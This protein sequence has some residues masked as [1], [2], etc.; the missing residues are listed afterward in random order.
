MIQLTSRGVVFSGSAA[1]LRALRAQ[2]K[3]DHYIILPKLIEPELLATILK[4]IESAPSIPK[5]FD[6]FVAQSIIDDPH[7]NALFLFLLCI[8]EFQRLI[9]RIAGCRRISDFHGRIYTL[10]PGTRDRIV[11][12]NDCVR[13]SHADVVP[14]PDYPG[15]SWRSPANPGKRLRKDFARSPQYGPRRC[16]FNAYFEKAGPSRAARRRRCSENR[17]G[18]V[19]SLGQRGCEFSFCVAQD[20]W[21]FGYPRSRRPNGIGRCR[22]G[23]QLA[24]DPSLFAAFFCWHM[25]NHFRLPCVLGCA[26][27]CIRSRLFAHA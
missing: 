14:E 18:R 9:Q 7:T 5:E 26:S 16:S 24:L 19:V 12:H 11:W 3:R 2:F 27:P 8:P 22:N 17:P 4:R 23:S 15:V 13:P 20:G 21:R 25:R 1:N 10:S 6:G